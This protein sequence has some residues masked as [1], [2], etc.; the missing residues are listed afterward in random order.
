[1]ERSDKKNG[2]DERI[3]AL[4]EEVK[5]L[6]AESA[7][8]KQEETKGVAGSILH[9]LGDVIPGLGGIVKGLEKS[10]TFRERL[11]AIDGEVDRKLRETPLKK[12]ETGKAPHIRT[13]FSVR[14]LAEDKGARGRTPALKVHREELKPE[15]LREVPVDVFD[16]GDHLRVVAE[17][18]GVEE[19]DIKVNLEAGKLTISAHTTD[20]K[21]HQEVKLPRVPGGS[22]KTRYKNGVLEVELEGC[23]P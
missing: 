2:E 19:T 22:P 10:D 16:E 5:R 1:M 14:S 4:E 7:Q 21:Y 17:L 6:K 12:V 11:E 23:E 9:G 15:K 13:D 20:R 18:P 3:K 8:E